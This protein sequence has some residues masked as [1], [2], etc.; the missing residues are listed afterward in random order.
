MRIDK[1]KVIN[2]TSNTIE[3]KITINIQHYKEVIP[4]HDYAKITNFF[5]EK[6]ADIEMVLEIEN[7]E[8]EEE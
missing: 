4:P 6:S 7:G 8:E 2:H 3:A 1:I 5:E